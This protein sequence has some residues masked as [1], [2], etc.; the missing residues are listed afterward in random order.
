MRRRFLLLLLLLSPAAPAQLAPLSPADDD[1]LRRPVQRVVL[2]GGEELMA[3]VRENLPREKREIF[4]RLK[5][6][7]PGSADREIRAESTLHFGGNPARA[8]Y[9]LLDGLGTALEKLVIAWK[10][11]GTPEFAFSSGPDLKADPTFQP[12]RPVAGLDFTWNDLSLAFLWWPGAQVR[13]LENR[14]L[15]WR[16]PRRRPRATRARQCGCGSTR[17][18]SW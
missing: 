11:D 9:L 17:R 18:R 7:V 15:R 12:S 5:V 16:S 4:A 6:R 14:K 2:P 1:L 13:G 3:E 10:P 8:E